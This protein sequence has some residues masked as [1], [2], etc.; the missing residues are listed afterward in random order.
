MGTPLLSIG[1]IIKNERRCLERCLRSL[2]ELRHTIPCELVIADTGSTDGSQ[3]IAQQYADLFFEIS[4]ENDFAAARNAVLDRCGGIWF[5]SLDADEWLED[6]RP[7]IKFLTDP[8]SQER[9][10][11]LSRVRNYLNREFTLYSDGF[12][13]RVALCRNGTLRFRHAIHENFCYND[14]YT[15]KVMILSDFIIHH[16]GYLYLD[17]QM[18]KE[19]K[20]RNM[21]LL[22]KELEKDPS[23]FRTLVQ[24]MQSAES[25]EERYQFAKDGLEQLRLHRNEDVVFAT[26]LYQTCIAAFEESDDWESTQA[27]LEEALEFCPQSYLIRTDGMGYGLLAAAHAGQYYLAVEYGLQWETALKEVEQGADLKQVERYY[28][29]IFCLTSNERIRMSVSLVVSLLVCQRNQEAAVRLAEL[30]LS[31]VHRKVLEPL[32]DALLKAK[33]SFSVFSSAMRQIWDS[34]QKNADTEIQ[35]LAPELR[36]DRDAALGVVHDYMKL[37]EGKKW[38]MSLC[39]MME[40]H[41]RERSYR[42]HVLSL[43]AG[44]GVDC[45]PAQSAALIQANSQTELRQAWDAVTDWTLIFVDAYLSVLEKGLEFPEGFYQQTLEQL[46]ETSASMA[47]LPDFPQIVDHWTSCTVW[48]NSL[49][50]LVWR[51]N[52]LASALRD[53]GWG[54]D[55][56]LGNRLCQ[57]FVTVGQK[58]L[59]QLYRLELLKEEQIHILPGMQRFAWHLHKAIRAEEQNKEL[60]YIQN[61]RAALQDAPAMKKMVDFLIKQREAQ[62]RRNVSPELLELA[63]K[64]RTIL[65]QYAPYDPAV[66]AL[67]QSEVYQKVAYLI[68]GIE[69]PVFGGQAQ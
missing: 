43:L 54:Q 40:K 8:A 27:A 63:E 65:A 2:E 48:G 12:I 6:I 58:Y 23:N 3:W 52:L 36:H 61:L 64:V 38:R 4:W 22:R 30:D 35:P 67:K 62:N 42:E 15:P 53:G 33:E 56:G 44:M 49:S 18:G 29:S 31:N 10:H 19:K 66:V 26:I 47:Q 14:G 7:L 28:S 41:L 69:A 21:I 20:R 1:M 9:A 55:A 16:D 13:G 59:Q 45:A 57:Q 37:S 39:K 51:F 46:A 24:C 25:V 50:K 34:A 11:V 5:F 60:V 68:E 17:P 32:V